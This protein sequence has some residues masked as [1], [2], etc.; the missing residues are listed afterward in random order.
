MRGDSLD[1]DA[2]SDADLIKLLKN[3]NQRRL[4]PRAGV[5]IERIFAV[6]QKRSLEFLRRNRNVELNAQGVLSAFGYKVGHDG[7]KDPEIRH[8]I[9][10]LIY[11]IDLPP[12]LNQDYMR[13]WGAPKSVQRKAKLI[14]VLSK[15]IESCKRRKANKLSYRLAVADWENDLAYVSA[16]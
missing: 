10:D 3:A 6:F 7:V 14:R 5:L 8:Q 2:K 1:L 16:A 13:E 12:V 9:L 15:F 11:Q 4:D